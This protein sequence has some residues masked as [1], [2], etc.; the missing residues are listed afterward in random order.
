MSNRLPYAVHTSAARAA[1]ATASGFSCGFEPMVAT[2]RLATVG[3][4]AAAGCGAKPAAGAAAAR[5][6][7]VLCCG[8]ACNDNMLREG[9]G[10]VFRVRVEVEVR[11]I[12]RVKGRCK[13]I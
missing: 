5:L 9:S 1:A 12:I 13:S 3:L 7:A 8:S 11:A 4:A 2:R 10:K 6:G